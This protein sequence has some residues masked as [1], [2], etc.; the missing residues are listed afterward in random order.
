MKIK[1]LIHELATIRQKNGDIEV[2][3]QIGERI[4]HIARSTTED[5][6]DRFDSQAAVVLIGE[7]PK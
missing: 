3:L 4:A 5:G 6:K 7:E 1:Q 2:M